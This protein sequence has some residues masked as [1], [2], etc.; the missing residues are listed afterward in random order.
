MYWTGAFRTSTRRNSNRVAVGYI[1]ILYSRTG[2]IYSIE[3]GT[4]IDLPERGI[5][6]E[7][8]HL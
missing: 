2:R 1:R 4:K 8:E 5:G 7:S 6:R 3:V